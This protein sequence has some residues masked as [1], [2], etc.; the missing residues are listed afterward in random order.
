MFTCHIKMNFF[1]KGSYL[2]MPQQHKNTA[3]NWTSG[4]FTDRPF[5]YLTAVPAAPVNVSVTQLRAHSAMVT[6]NV[7]QGDTVI[8]YA[9]SQQVQCSGSGLIPPLCVCLC[10]CALTYHPW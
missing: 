4:F 5:V 3:A 2:E 7:P 8:G 9:I 1:R 6:W 10:V